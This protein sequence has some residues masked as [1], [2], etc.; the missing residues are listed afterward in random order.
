MRRIL[1]YLISFFLFST[2]SYSQN[3]CDIELSPV[4]SSETLDAE[5]PESPSIG[6]VTI[7]NNESFLIQDVVWYYVKIQEAGTFTF[8]IHKPAYYDYDFAVWLNPNCQNLGMPDRASFL[9]DNYFNITETGLQLD[10]QGTCENAG[11][12]IGDIGQPGVVRHLDVQEDDEIYI[13][14][15]KPTQSSSDEDF[16]MSFEGTAVLDCTIVGNSYGKCDVNNDGQESFNLS[17]ILPDLQDEYP[18]IDNFEFYNN[19]DDAETGTG[20][21]VTFPLNVFLAN[22]PTEVYARG[23]NN[24]GVLERVVKIFLYVNQVPQINSP[25]E[26]D[27]VCDADGDGLGIFDLTD[28]ENQV[29]PG[30]NNF[31]FLYY[32]TLTDAQ[33]GGTNNI[34]PANAYESGTATV[35]VRVL[36]S[37]LE[38]NEEGCFSIGEIHLSLTDS[39]EPEFDIL[40]SYC[41]NST[42]SDL[43]LISENGITGTWN[44]PIDTSVLGTEIYI[45]TPD[46]GQ[47]AL[48]YELEI[49]ILDQITPEFTLEYSYCTGETP[50]D[51]PLVSDNGIAGTWNAPIDTS[52]P[53]T[54]NYTFTPNEGQCSE[55]IEIE[56]V[57]T[58]GMLPE[59]E[60]EDYFCVGEELPTLSST[61]DNGMP[62]TWVPSV[63]SNTPGISVYTFTPDESECTQLFEIEIEIAEGVELNENLQKSLCDEDWDGIFE[64]DLTLLNEDL[65]INP[66]E[67]T[68]Y[69][70]TSQT[71]AQNDV[72]ISQ[73]QWNNYQFVNLPTSIWVVATNA[74]GCRSI[75][76]EVEFIANPEVAHNGDE[77][78]PIEFCAYEPQDLT[79]YENIINPSN[80]VSYTYF[81]SQL[82]AENA[83]VDPTAYV[84]ENESGTVFVRLEETNRCPVILPIH[85]LQKVTPQLFGLTSNE[86][87]CNGDVLEVTVSSDDPDAVFEW[88]SEAGETFIGGT[89]TFTGTGAY[90]VI[91]IGSNGCESQPQTFTISLP[92]QPVITGIE[93][94]KDFITVFAENS[95]NGP[96]EYSLDGI[97]WQ[98]TNQ[99]SN[100]IP[101]QEYTIYVRSEGCMITTY[102]MTLINVPNFVSPNDDGYNDVW[103]IRGVEATS[104][105]TIQIFDRNGKIL[106]D[107]NFEGNYFW[108]G[109]YAGRP[110]ASG[111]YWFIVNVPSDGV[112]KD[113]KFVGHIS[114]R[115]Q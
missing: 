94:G 65:A 1:F 54:I 91:A 52:S 96:M 36:N 24:S 38:G 104:G 42:A 8:L 18:N 35:Y 49:E 71:N 107:T 30:L 85:Y 51:L 33:N 7:C 31:T 108:D 106:V 50:Q 102:K 23:E 73:N 48:E 34:T 4:C 45:F 53:G 78:G 26:L 47:C 17:D 101:G 12:G 68:F 75:E 98:T 59:F 115:N 103:E 2:F 5:A 63:I 19:Q 56:I 39:L 112:I 114:I 29:F 21:P 72:P 6:F 93:S 86:T 67:L 40:D 110:V 64:T 82:N 62:G 44:A 37:P 95:G 111:D 79:V 80:T 105:S 100:L 58:E 43:P 32:E 74:G 10:E 16:T 15:Y 57:V 11:F 90:T 99:F 81:E 13:M 113:Q 69:Y 14:V 9:A 55:I 25:I 41:L 89:Q 70:Y 97:L 88:T 60:L 46:E 84:F 20:T 3:I 22:N 61:S 83:I 109:K 92:E 76:V 27:P 77:F 87:L 66:D 28:A